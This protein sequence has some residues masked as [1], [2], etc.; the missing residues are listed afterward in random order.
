MKKEELELLVEKNEGLK[1]FLKETP[2]GIIRK[3]ENRAFFNLC[4]GEKMIKIGQYQNRSNGGGK[5]HEIELPGILY[6][7]IKCNDWYEI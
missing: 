1:V 2:E 4:C 6:Y 5:T 7:C 3:I